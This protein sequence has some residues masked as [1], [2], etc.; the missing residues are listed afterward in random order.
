LVAPKHAE[1]VGWVLL[2]QVVE[3]PYLFPEK[4]KKRLA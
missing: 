4:T 3:I 2:K 1:T